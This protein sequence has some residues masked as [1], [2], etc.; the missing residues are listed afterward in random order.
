MKQKLK[1]TYMDV[2][3]RFSQLS[4]ARRLQVGCCIVKDDIM[5]P[6][7]NGTPAGWDNNCEDRI[8]MDQGAGGWLGPEEIEAQWPYEETVVVANDNESFETTRRYRLKT[9]PEVLHAEPNALAKMLKA[10]MSTRDSDVFVTHA[11]CIDCAK[12]LSQAGVRSVTYGMAYRDTAGVDFLV[13][14]GV[15]VEQ[16]SD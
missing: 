9:K 6:G 7:Y 14:S 8:W 13:K 1:Q 4:H 3:K 12:I 5:H 10:G 15:I 11:P 2:A 16:Y